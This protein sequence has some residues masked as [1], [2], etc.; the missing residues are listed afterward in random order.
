MVNITSGKDLKQK[1]NKF[2]V[3]NLANNSDLNTKLATLASKSE[4]KVGQNKIVKFQAVDSSG[5]K[6]DGTQNY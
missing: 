5:I 4:L 3:F 2:E 1:W 6:D